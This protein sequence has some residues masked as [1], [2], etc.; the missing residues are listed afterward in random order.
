M[1]VVGDGFVLLVG[2][3]VDFGSQISG[4]VQHGRRGF[5]RSG[6]ADRVGRNGFYGDGFADVGLSMAMDLRL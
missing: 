1:V 5:G 6:L 4:F 2:L 3:M